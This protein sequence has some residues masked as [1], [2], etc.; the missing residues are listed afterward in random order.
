VRGGPEAGEGKCPTCGAVAGDRSQVQ[1]RLRELER[2][3]ARR[4]TAEPLPAG[5][6]TATG[7]SRRA[8]EGAAGSEDRP[9]M[10][11]QILAASFLFGPAAGGVI[12][13]INFARMGK[14]QYR[15]PTI[16]VAS[17][18]F[19]LEACV[20]IFVVPEAAARSVG[21]L[22]NLGIGLMFMQAQKPFFDAWQ[23][24]NWAPAKEGERYKPTRI[25][26][27][28]L[29]GLFFFAGEVG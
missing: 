9:W 27:L 4:R 24:V 16:V 18:L 29:V 26:Q 1:A 21:L 22:A 6:Q 23:A 13:G 5:G 10:P 14:R 19:L 7:P 25:G 20:L 12:A 28:F 15:V 11:S 3:R 8:P 2:D 17:F